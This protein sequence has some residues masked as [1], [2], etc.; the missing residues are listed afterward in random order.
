MTPKPNKAFFQRSELLLGHETM[1]RIQAA[2][3]IIFGVGGVGS[4]CAEALVRTG[5]QQVTLVDADVICATNVNR[6]LQ[7]T[8]ENIGQP[9]AE[10]LRQRLLEINPAAEITAHKLFYDETT[11]GQFDFTQY[12]YVIDAIDTL[13]NKVLLLTR[14]VAAGATVYASM[15]AALKLDPTQ[16]RTA[17]L[18]RTKHCPLA[19]NVRQRLRHDG[20]EAK[21]LCVYSEELPQ[22]NKGKSACGSAECVCPKKHELDLCS[23]KAQI[24]G[25]LVHVTAVFGFTL[26]GLVIQDL[27]QEPAAAE[28]ADILT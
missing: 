11:C 26:A 21:F 2:R 15:G 19:R 25:A 16:V 24:N 6:Q 14:C 5:V 17:R 27:A 22:V 18:D 13:R 1:R 12:D 4:W 9:K 20:V 28:K 3:V 8:A 10:E 7:A 23:L